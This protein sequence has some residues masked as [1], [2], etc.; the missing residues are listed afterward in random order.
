MPKHER[1]EELCAA[2][3]LGEA[4]GSE[5]AELQQH[6]KECSECART[7]A[8]F[9]DFSASRFTGGER[10]H[11]LSNHDA[12]ACIDSD[13]F[14][15]RFLRNA[16]AEGI[17]FSAHSLSAS[18]WEHGSPAVVAPS[19]ARDWFPGWAR[20]VAASIAIAAC[21]FGGYYW[22]NRDRIVPP[23]LVVAIPGA[24]P[25][26]VAAPKS[27]EKN[28]ETTG[29]VAASRI[30]S[31][32]TE[33]EILKARLANLSASLT[34]LEPVKAM[35]EKERLSLLAIVRERD[36][37]IADMQA[38]LDQTQTAAAGVRAELEV[39]QAKA[40]GSQALIAEAHAKVRDL[41]TQLSEKSAALERERELLVAGRDVRELMAARNLHIVDVFDTDPRG[42]TRPS[43]GRIFF[44]E[45]KSLI[46]Y[47]YDLNAAGAIQVGYKFQ[48][49]GRKE[50]P[51]ERAR[52]LGI[53]YS[54]NQAQKRWV[55]QFDDPKVLSEIDSVFVTLEPPNGSPTQPKGAKLMYAYLRGQANHP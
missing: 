51:A 21:V 32:T 7:Y 47:A 18:A 15:E 24:P 38:R 23:R 29:P 54:D 30:R 43:F 14:R 4:S 36:S 8:E 52:S 1:F 16:Q 27:V 17:V 13:L 53:F 9:L 31:L 46:F 45:G 3:S 22:G 2:A 40:T 41:S 48:V 55:F 50:G 28:P 33:I 49:W 25:S 5:L 10:R 20:A 39:A 26:L 34:E 42:K 35:S 12:I 19:R 11:D 6:L 37:A 44:T